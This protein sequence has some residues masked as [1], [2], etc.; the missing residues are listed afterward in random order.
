MSSASHSSVGLVKARMAG[1][2]RSGS[3]RDG[4]S[5]VIGS[6]LDWAVEAGWW[7]GRAGPRPALHGWVPGQTC[8]RKGAIHDER[9]GA[10]RRRGVV[11]AGSGWGCWPLR[12]LRIGGRGRI[13]V[14]EVLVDPSRMASQ[15]SVSKAVDVFVL[16]EMDGW[17]RGLG[18]DR[19]GFRQ[20]EA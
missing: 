15:S 13:A 20:C 5:L 7:G 3:R 4:R 18:R 19:R 10:S 6:G 1:L 14:G 17:M 8:G 9:F 16:G 11:W 12:G 2:L